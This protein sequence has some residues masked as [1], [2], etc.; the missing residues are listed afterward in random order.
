MVRDVKAQFRLDIVFRLGTVAL[1]MIISKLFSAMYRTMSLLTLA[2]RFLHEALYLLLL[3][4][5]IVAYFFS[6]VLCRTE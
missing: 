6:Y 4:Y 3:F 1:E 2:H 5:I